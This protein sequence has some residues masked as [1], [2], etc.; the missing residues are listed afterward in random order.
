[1]DGPHKTAGHLQN[2]PKARLPLGASGSQSALYSIQG[3]PIFK[4]IIGG[5]EE[6]AGAQI[7]K[8][9][10]LT[11]EEKIRMAP[12]QHRLKLLPGGAGGHGSGAMPTSESN[13]SRYRGYDPRRGQR[14]ER[15]MGQ[16][17]GRREQ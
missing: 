17:G 7:A 11:E 13:R 12:W 1:M 4:Y 15:H 8:G 2:A 14:H 9:A 5:S 6:V 16:E 3:R 10:F